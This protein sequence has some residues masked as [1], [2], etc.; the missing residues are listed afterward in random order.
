[1]QGAPLVALF[2]HTGAD[3]AVAHALQVIGQAVVSHVKPA[4]N[5]AQY[6][7]GERV[8]SLGGVLAVEGLHFVA[9]GQHVKRAGG[10]DLHRGAIVVIV[11]RGGAAV[12]ADDEAQRIGPFAGGQQ[13]AAV[14]FAQVVHAEHAGVHPRDAAHLL[15]R[16]GHVDVHDFTGGNAG[17]AAGGGVCAV[18]EPVGL[19]ALVGV[20]LH[21]HD[22]GVAAAGG[23]LVALGVDAGH[24][25]QLQCKALGIAS[26]TAT[27]DAGQGLSVA[28]HGDHHHP[29]G[30]GK[31]HAAGDFGTATAGPAEVGSLDGCIGQAVRL[32]GGVLHAGLEREA[33][34]AHYVAGHHA[35]ELARV[36]IVF[37]Q[38]AGAG[39]EGVEVAAQL[40]VDGALARQP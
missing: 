33:G 19:G 9:F 13:G 31:A 29:A 3:A 24:V 25:Q 14:E 26:G 17:C 34:G 38:V 7:L 36:V 11:G 30:V 22:D 12:G 2:Q 18:F 35:Q 6:G 39:A 16:L 37:A 40:V 10:A 28:G 15:G 27:H 8:E 20:Y 4:G 32:A 21:A 1:M 23:G 5:A